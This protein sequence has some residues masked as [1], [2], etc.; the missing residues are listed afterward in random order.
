MKLGQGYV[1]TCIYDSVHRGVPGPGGY[2]VPEDGTWFHG[3]CLVPGVS[4]PGGVPAPWGACSQ[5]G[6]CSQGVP[7]GDPPLQLLLRAV[8]ILLECVLV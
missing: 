5:R 4:A 7:D 2:L 6:A 8:R 1:F 3:G